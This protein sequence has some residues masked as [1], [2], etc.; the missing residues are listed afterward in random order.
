MP[1]YIKKKLQE[2]KHVIKKMNQ[3]CPY[4]TP[5]PKQYGSEAQIPPASWQLTAP[6]SKSGIKR[7]Q[8][9]VGS[10]F[11][12]TWAVSMTV[13]MA[14]SMITAKQTKAMTK[15]GFILCGS[16]IYRAL[17]FFYEKTLL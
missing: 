3:M 8:Q 5:A 4:Y 2:Y 15:T 6:L 9:I 7:V 17:T 11:Y 14:L 16:V 1:G 10:I 12:Y 13:L